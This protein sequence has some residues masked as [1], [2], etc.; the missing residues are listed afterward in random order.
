[1]L[2]L[3]VIVVVIIAQVVGHDNQWVAKKAFPG[4][5]SLQCGAVHWENMGSG[6]LHFG[7]SAPESCSAKA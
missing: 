6:V 3:A 1:L 2:S 4:F 7:R 5:V